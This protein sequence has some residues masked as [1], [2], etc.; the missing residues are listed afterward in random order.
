MRTPW[1]VAVFVYRGDRLLI[2]RR[3]GEQYWHVV[4]GVVEHGEG[5]VEAAGRELREESGLDVGD[6]LIDLE[7]PL[8]YALTKEFRERYGFPP[9]QGVV[10]TYNFA[11]EAP[12]GWE[13]V[14]NEEHDAYRWCSFDEAASSLYW[15]SARDIA[16]E[17]A[18]RPR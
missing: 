2:L 4:A 12:S 14:L 18:I 9:D 5:Y 13:P 11:A 10:T 17:L 1:E 16:R 15:S 3:V 6:R 7:Q 8:T